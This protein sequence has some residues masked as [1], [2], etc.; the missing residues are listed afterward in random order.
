MKDEISIDK[1]TLYSILLLTEK[2]KPCNYESIVEKSFT[3]FPER[4]RMQVNKNWPDGKKIVLSI[5]RCRDRGWILGSESEGFRLTPLGER[6]G[7][8]VE[9]LVKGKPQS[10]KSRATEKVNKTV[11]G[12]LVN[13]M[14]KTELFKKWEKDHKAI[15]NEDEF[16]SFLQVSYEASQKVCKE[17]IS[18]YRG[19]AGMVGDKEVLAFLDYL[20]ETFKGL[21]STW[22][23][24]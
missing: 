8:E 21:V 12:E 10:G 15:L 22:R 19:A 14:K 2:G 20:S 7:K 9:E 3:E 16:R 6:D 4:F 13:Y 17:R 24:K 1:L 11:E 23:V 18:K 5:Q